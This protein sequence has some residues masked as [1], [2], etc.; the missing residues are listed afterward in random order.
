METGE[1]LNYR[2]VLEKSLKLAISLEKLGFKLNDRIGICSENNLNFGIAILSSIFL[3]TAICPIN[4]TYIEREIIHILTIS[5]PKCIFVSISCLS[6][7]QKIVK[8]LPWHPKLI[9]LYPYNSTSAIPDVPDLIAKIADSELRN[10]KLP[11]IDINDHVVLIACSSGTTGLPK[12]VMLSDKNILAQML[13]LEDMNSSNLNINS[14]VLGMLP[15][16]HAYGF[17]VF[18]SSLVFGKKFIVLSKF[19]EQLFLEAV[20]KYRID[21]LSLVP[22]LMVF[23]AKNPIVNKYD[24][25]CVKK[26][27]LVDNFLVQRNTWKKI[28][29]E[30]RTYYLKYRQF[31]IFLMQR[32][33]CIFIIFILNVLLQ[34][35]CCFISE[36]NWG[37]Y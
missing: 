16:F 31:N 21:T 10:F 6:R 24:L 12:G 30:S 1:E 37:G 22:P 4:P 32:N 3:G 34:M 23:L 26:I 9:L 19:N 2:E 14:S 17:F 28:N 5:K 33:I 15:M 27:T 7:M 35:W 20:E 8:N 29:I 18:L 13:C 11:K 36:R 25:S